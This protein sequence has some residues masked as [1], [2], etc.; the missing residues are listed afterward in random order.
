MEQ[1]PGRVPGRGTQQDVYAQVEKLGVSLNR[2]IRPGTKSTEIWHNTVSS[3]L[4]EHP[5]FVMT[6]ESAPNIAAAEQHARVAKTLP[7]WQYTPPAEGAPGPSALQL[8]HNL[9]G[10]KQPSKATA[11]KK[12]LDTVKAFRK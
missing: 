8:R 5:E 3:V 12:Q 4:S 9:H 6:G 11:A 1:L 7:I 2:S 10:P